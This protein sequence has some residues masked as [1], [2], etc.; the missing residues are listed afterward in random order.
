MA[1]TY[2]PTD[3]NLTCSSNERVCLPAATG[4]EV[5]VLVGSPFADHQCENDEILVLIASVYTLPKPTAKLMN[6]GGLLKKNHKQAMPKKKKEKKERKE[7]IMSSVAL[8][9]YFHLPF[10]TGPGSAWRQR[11][12]HRAVFSFVILFFL[13]AKGP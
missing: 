2:F 6:Y 11:K 5:S 3:P 10:F 9:V 4:V 12:M 8:H 1:S 7:P 13:A